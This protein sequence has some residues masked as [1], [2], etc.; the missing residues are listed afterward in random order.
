MRSGLE[1]LTV[2]GEGS[3]T[4][5]GFRLLKVFGAG[6]VCCVLF[7]AAD[8]VA[9]VGGGGGVSRGGGVVVD[10]VM[11]WPR[12]LAVVVARR[13]R[14]VSCFEN[15][16]EWPFPARSGMSWYPSGRS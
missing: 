4:P 8:L 16:T 5:P 3:T 12:E 14:I 1:A 6:P 7:F 15:A 2:S 13:R 9:L 11:C 10:V